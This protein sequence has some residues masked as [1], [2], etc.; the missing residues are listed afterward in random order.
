MHAQVRAADVERGVE[1]LI[2]GLGKEGS[3][4]AVGFSS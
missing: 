3:F 4:A 2:R 1:G